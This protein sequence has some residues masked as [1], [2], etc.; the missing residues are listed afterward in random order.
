MAR[1]LD[2]VVCA[3]CHVTLRCVK[4]SFPVKD[5]A[6]G[7]FESTYWSGDLYECP[8]CH[9]QVVKGFG[10]GVV[11]SEN[12]ESVEYM[13]RNYRALEFTYA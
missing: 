3:K 4:N 7:V 10:T 5:Q 9:A 12:P 6:A 8:L 1:P 2:Y 13:E 11:K